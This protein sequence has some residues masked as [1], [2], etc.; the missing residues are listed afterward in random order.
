MLKLHEVANAPIF[1][2][3]VNQLGQGIVGGRLVD[4]EE[5]SRKAATAAARIL[6]GESPGS[7]QLP[8][9]R[10]G[11]PEFDWR[12]LRRWGISEAR[13]PPGSLVGFR[14]PGIWE[15][16]WWLVCGGILFGTAEAL[17]IVGLVVNRV[18]RRH[19]ETVATL[20][21]DLSSRFINLPADKVDP[22]IEAAQRRICECLGL[23]I[24]ALWQWS[25]DHPD[26][27]V[28]THACRLQDGPP[29]PERM[30]AQEYFPWS[31]QEERGSPTY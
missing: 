11:P 31:L 22:E 26:D 29:I 19:A 7:I 16:Y 4:L 27:L 15:R 13:L 2:L 25:V 21:A 5:Y 28:L 9:Q 1:G 24:S 18:K 12:E 20:I 30:S 8:P 17:L 10:V 14:Q 3:W 6:H 23:D